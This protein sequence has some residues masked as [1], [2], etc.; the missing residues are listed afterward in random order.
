MAELIVRLPGVAERRAQLSRR[1]ITLGRSDTCDINLRSDEVSRV[2]AE[3][4]LAS[5]P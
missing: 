3:V 2:H 5:R 1:P 4:W